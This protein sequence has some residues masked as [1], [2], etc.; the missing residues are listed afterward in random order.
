MRKKEYPL[1]PTLL[2][3]LIFTVIFSSIGIARS[4]P[5]HEKPEILILRKETV[6]GW[7]GQPTLLLDYM[8]GGILV[9]ANYHPYEM[10][11]YRETIAHLK[12]SGRVRYASPMVEPLK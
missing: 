12:R 10:D 4:I 7:D 2:V 6:A 8:V 5:E 3:I 11:L 1:I 9:P